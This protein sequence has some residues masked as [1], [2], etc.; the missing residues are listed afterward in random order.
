MEEE[1]KILLT[2]LNSIDD[3]KTRQFI[4]SEQ[5]RIVQKRTKQQQGETTP[6][7]YGQYFGD[8]GGSGSNLP[9]Y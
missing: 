5:E 4:Q 7:L 6:N 9:E 2:N 8:L 1:N 3:S